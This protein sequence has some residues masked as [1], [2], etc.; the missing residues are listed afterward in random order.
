M[1]FDE[2]YLKSVI[3]AVPNWPEEGIV[4][5]DIAPLFLEPKALHMV[6]DT[7]TQ[8]YMGSNI[9][10]IAS[11]DARGFLV[12][13]VVAYKL[14]LPLIL[15]RKKGKLPGDTVQEEYTLE[16]GTSIVEMQK[17]AC[18]EGDNVLIMDDLIA[19]GGTILAASTLIR[20][21]GGNVV[22]AAAVIDLPDLQG[23]TKIQ[24]ADIPV[25]T[26]IAY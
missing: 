17:D 19:T 5:R 6:T 24:E 4:F 11:L 3:R 9:T 21:L 15:I 7:F 14:N 26:L 18:G 13:S 22:E 12:G 20:R 8:H 10:H 16:Y 2:C 1:S 25:H 23:S